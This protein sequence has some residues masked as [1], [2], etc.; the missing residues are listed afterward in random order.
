MA[1]R[2]YTPARLTVVQV[3][4]Q[5]R[6]TLAESTRAAIVPFAFSDAALHHA[7]QPRE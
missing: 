1:G 6:Q 4:Y 7:H 2:L 3:P 5:S